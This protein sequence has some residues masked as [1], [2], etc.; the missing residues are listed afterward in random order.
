MNRRVLKIFFIALLFLSAL[1]YGIILF[2]TIS[3]NRIV[4]GTDIY[5]FIPQQA[6]YVVSFNRKY[7]F[8]EY[9]ELDSTNSSLIN[10]INDYI[11]YPMLIVKNKSE[12]D[13][14]LCRVTKEQENQIKSVLENRIAPYQLPL[15]RKENDSDLYFYPLPE[16]KFLIAILKNGVLALSMDYRRIDDFLHNSHSNQNLITGADDQIIRYVKR[17]NDN[18]P[19]SFFISADNTFFALSYV[20]T[21]D[22]I[23]FDGK[24]FGKL[25]NDSVKLSYNEMNHLLRLNTHYTDSIVWE[26]DG[27]L[28]I[29]V[30]KV[31]QSLLSE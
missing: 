21:K 24:Y 1:V 13:L 16:N 7:L 23:N 18:S 15:K 25:R 2:Q 29:Y 19:I 6:D 17:N 9:F 11:T 30:N 10:A 28:K 31:R 27:D 14:I 12:D 26:E 4:V 3:H 8:D 22:Y 5:R 20:Y